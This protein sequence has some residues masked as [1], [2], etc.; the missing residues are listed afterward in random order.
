MADEDS[1]T[2]NYINNPPYIGAKGSFDLIW[3]LVKS[4]TNLQ[5]FPSLSKP[6]VL[7]Y[8]EI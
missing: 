4:L 6:E 1:W 8:G 3:K 5:S 2:D 7:I